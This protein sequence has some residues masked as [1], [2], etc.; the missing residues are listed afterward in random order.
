VP[1]RATLERQAGVELE[2]LADVQDRQ[3]QTPSAAAAVVLERI[4]QEQAAR[5][6]RRLLTAADDADA[7]ATARQRIIDLR[8]AVDDVEDSLEWPATVREAQ[9]L[10]HELNDLVLDHGIDE[11]RRSAELVFAR[12]AEAE[13]HHDLAALRRAIGL[14]HSVGLRVLDRI[15]RLQFMLFERHT[16]HLHEANDPTLA[17]ILHERGRQAVANGD[18]EQLRVINRRLWDLFDDGDGRVDSFSTVRRG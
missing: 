3:A 2:R 1:D 8:A 10:R 11:E 6:I 15:G 9:G 18:V 4:E 12:L 7:A 13:E 14:G 17:R 16:E 5:E